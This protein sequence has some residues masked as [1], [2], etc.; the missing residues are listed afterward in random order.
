[1]LIIF[2]ANSPPI[3]TVEGSVIAILDQEVSL[4]FTVEDIDND[5]ITVTITSDIPGI[6]LD[7]STMIISF[8]LTDITTSY[9]LAYVHKYNK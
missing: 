1:M 2:A 4:S 3:L 9:S 5:D 8:T 7:T 6:S